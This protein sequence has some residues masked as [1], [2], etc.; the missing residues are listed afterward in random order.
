MPPPTSCVCKSH[1]IEAKRYITD[2]SYIPKWKRAKRATDS[3]K[4]SYPDCSDAGKLI[5]PS[6]EAHDVIKS[7][8]K[9]PNTSD[10]LLLCN[11]HYQMAYKEFS[12]T[13]PSPCAACNAVPKQGVLYNRHCPNPTVINEHMN[14]TFGTNISLNN[15]DNI[16][17]MNS[18]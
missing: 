11:R 5:V 1:Y 12:V 9:V 14:S 6:F 8:I 13:T 15:S 17:Y 3:K 2:T 16:C 7:Y 10:D 4:C 18:I